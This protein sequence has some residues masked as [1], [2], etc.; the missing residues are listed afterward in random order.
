MSVYALSDE[1]EV[2]PLAQCAAQQEGVEADPVRF[3]RTRL[4]F[5]PDAAQCHVLGGHHRRLLLNCSRQ[6][7]KSTVTAVKV[8]H[9]LVSRP[10]AL[11][12]VGSKTLRQSG[13]LVAKVKSFGMRMGVR[14][15]GDGMNPVS[16]VLPNGS[17]LVGLPGRSGN[18]IRGFSAV[19]L[20][21]LDEAAQVVDE[22]YYA[23][24]PMVAVRDGDIWLLS[25]PYGKRG[26]F[27]H[28]WQHGGERW[29]RVRV[30]AAE[31]PRISAEFLEEERQ[32]GGEDYFRQE[33]CCEFVDVDG[34][35]FSRDVVERAFRE[36]VS[37]LL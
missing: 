12:L 22:V 8:L 27:F 21:I 13:E 2:L 35:M 19:D 37:V 29:E 5:D 25:T 1:R 20:L 36:D 15:R 11:V 28:E 16:A 14:M 10:G 23:V 24:R 4:G 9:L 34:S 26:F 30:P 31:C 32:T 17:R 18:E 7:G 6:W 3:A 33:Y